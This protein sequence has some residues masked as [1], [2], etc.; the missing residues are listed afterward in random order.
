MITAVI[1]SYHWQIQK[2]ALSNE[3]LSFLLYMFNLIIYVILSENVFYSVKKLIP[4]F[5]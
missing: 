3:G 1:T 5:I 2:L 4:M